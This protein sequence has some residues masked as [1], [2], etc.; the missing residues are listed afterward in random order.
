M[1]PEAVASD[2]VEGADGVPHA[3]GSALVVVNHVGMSDY[4]ASVVGSEYG[5]PEI[6]GVKAQAV[7]ARTYAVRAVDP[8]RAYDLDDDQRSQVYRGVG[9]VTATSERAER[10]TRGEVGRV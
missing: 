6:E 7:L 4:V 10:E 8:R 9:A 1:S 2:Q 5:F 3:V